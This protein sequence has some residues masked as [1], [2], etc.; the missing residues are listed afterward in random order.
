MKRLLFI[1]L[2]L[3]FL[4]FNANLFCETD[5]ANEN[6]SSGQQQN[7]GTANEQ[8]NPQ[9]N[10]QGSS[11]PADERANAQENQSDSRANTGETGTI[12]KRRAAGYFSA[13]MK[14]FRKRNYYRAV[15]WYKRAVK[16]NPS[17]AKYYY[18]LGRALDHIKNYPASVEALKKAQEI[19]PELR[20][21]RYPERL[22]K[23]IIEIAELA[24][25]HGD[26]SRRERG[27]EREREGNEGEQESGREGGRSP[28][29]NILG[30]SLLGLAAFL[31]LLYFIRKKKRSY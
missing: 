30:F 15:K 27:R 6:T 26:M 18:Y 10:Q 5:T 17:R 9:E 29:W 20:F 23:K 31:A 24:Q 25:K 28:L 21:T 19:D 11:A 16:Y 8:N 4:L 13:G 1:H 7:A 3:L 2:I 12:N 22:K 14:A